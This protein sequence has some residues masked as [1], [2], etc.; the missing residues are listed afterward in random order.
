MCSI[1]SRFTY[2]LTLL[3]SRQIRQLRLLRTFL[4]ALRALRTLRWVLYEDRRLV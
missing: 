1:N 4:R 2:S 3:N